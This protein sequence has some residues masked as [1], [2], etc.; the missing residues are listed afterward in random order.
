[1]PYFSIQ[2]SKILDKAQADAL[3]VKAS[4]F[5]AK[6]LGKPEQYV[7]TAIIHSVSMSFAGSAGAPAALVCLKS[8]GLAKDRCPELS[9]AICGFLNDELGVSPDRTFI[10][11]N[12]L[13]GGLFGWNSKTF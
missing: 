4:G 3:S 12:P 9:K 10:D 5:I 6:T 13:D 1:M 7:M 11:F 2:T 8:I